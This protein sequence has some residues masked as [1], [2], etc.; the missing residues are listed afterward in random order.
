MT[1]LLFVIVPSTSKKA[2][3]FFDVLASDEIVVQCVRLG[4][5]MRHGPHTNVSNIALPTGCLFHG[6][7][8]RWLRLFP[9]RARLILCRVCK[10]LVFPTCAS[11][12]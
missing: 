2:A 3:R 12:Q 8:A 1:T 5:R 9:R 10:H 6:L 4:V 7:V 11:Q